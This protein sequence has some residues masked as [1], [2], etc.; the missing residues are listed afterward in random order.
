[1]GVECSGGTMNDDKLLRW[2]TRGRRAFGARISMHASD[3]LEVPEFDDD[4]ATAEDD[5]R[6][7]SGGVG[8]CTTTLAGVEDA[9]VPLD[10]GE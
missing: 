3:P 10:G 5:G 9:S 6:R 1:M 8:G 4:D 7:A 2:C